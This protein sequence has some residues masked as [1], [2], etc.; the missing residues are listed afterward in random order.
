MRH[1]IDLLIVVIIV[2]LFTPNCQ[3]FHM[4][5]S[6]S[7]SLRL[8]ARARTAAHHAAVI[9]PAKA[10]ARESPRMVVY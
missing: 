8:L 9:T 3:A 6:A 1:C 10:Y 4:M 7:S 5:S 2:A